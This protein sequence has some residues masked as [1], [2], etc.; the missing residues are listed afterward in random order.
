M[1]HAFPKRE[2]LKCNILV[3]YYANARA[4]KLATPRV[5]AVTGGALSYRSNTG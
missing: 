5:V 1:P 3:A 4:R 2:A